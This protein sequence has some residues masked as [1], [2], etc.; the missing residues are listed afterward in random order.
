VINVGLVNVR[1]VIISNHFFIYY[2]IKFTN[3]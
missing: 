2:I 3:C 1:V